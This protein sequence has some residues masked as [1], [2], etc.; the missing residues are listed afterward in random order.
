VAVRVI[1][2]SMSGVSG[3]AADNVTVEGHSALQAP[4]AVLE[5]D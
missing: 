2:G 5:I 3:I 1:E 4:E